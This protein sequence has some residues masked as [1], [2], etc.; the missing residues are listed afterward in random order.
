M[1]VRKKGDKKMFNRVL[2]KNQLK[3][4]GFGACFVLG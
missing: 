4:L 2:K 3:N 1:I